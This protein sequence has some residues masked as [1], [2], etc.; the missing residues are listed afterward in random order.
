MRQESI[1]FMAL[2]G[3]SCR[4]SLDPLALLEETP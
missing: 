1:T 4:E 3:T 2:N